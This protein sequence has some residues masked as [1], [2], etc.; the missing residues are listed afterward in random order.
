[1]KT[2]VLR[3]SAATLA[4]TF[5]VGEEP[6]DSTTPVTVAV[7]DANGTAVT[8]GTAVS[9]GVDSGRYTF[10]LPGQ[11]LL[12]QLTVAWS[13]TIAGAA[14]VQTDEVEIVGGFFFSLAQGRGSDSSLSD[15]AKYPATELEVARLQTEEE[16]EAICDRAFVPRYA[17]MVLDGTGE[18]DLVLTHPGPERSLA[19]VRSI[20]SVTMAPRADEAFTAFDTA[21]LAALQV[22]DDGTLRRLDGAL[23][24]RGYGNVVVELEYGLPA[25]S[26]DLVRAA[27]TRFRTWLNVARSGV[28]DRASSFTISDGGTYRLDMPG[29]FKTGIPPVDAAYARYSRRD[30]AGGRKVP[31]S[32]SLN[33]DPQFS[34]MF[35]G[36]RR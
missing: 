8:S 25:P 29:P 31:A 24:T 11:A 22:A 17:R 26:A 15:P 18:S 4:H 2:R 16:C 27:L 20:R 35:H 10:P 9:A 3:T 23:F 21:E 6:T 36:G 14:V 5:E 13:A 12:G 32:R 7:T 33:F 30:G 1:M 34:S 19:D 28:P